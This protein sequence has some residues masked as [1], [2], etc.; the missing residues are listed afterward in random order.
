M[1]SEHFTVSDSIEYLPCQCDENSPFSGRSER[2]VFRSGGNRFLIHKGIVPVERV[3]FSFFGRENIHFLLSWEGFF[4][5]IRL[6]LGGSLRI[7]Q[8]PA[9][10]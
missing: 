8:C 5:K 4:H 9:P 6:G 3:L 2:R 10:K 7:G 1:W